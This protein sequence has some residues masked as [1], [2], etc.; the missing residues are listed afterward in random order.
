MGCLQ[1]FWMVLGFLFILEHLIKTLLVV[2]SPS[3]AQ[4][5]SALLSPLAQTALA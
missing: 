3:L 4:S 5:P 1:A 2:I